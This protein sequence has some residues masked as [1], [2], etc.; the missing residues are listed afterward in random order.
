MWDLDRLAREGQQAWPRVTLSPA[1]LAAAV[2]ERLA[3]DDL[4]G[5]DLYLAIALEL[6]DRAALDLFEQRFVPGL[7]AALGR[8]CRSAAVID[9]V[10]QQVRVRVLV[11]EPDRPARIGSYTGR[12]HLG[13]WLR[14]TA[15]RTLANLARG[16]QR[17]AGAADR[18]AVGD[19]AGSMTW[20]SPERLLLDQ[21]HGG[22]LR[23]ALADGLRALPPRDR[24]L[25]RLHYLE[26]L[27]LDRIATV[28]AVNKSTVSRWLAGARDELLRRALAA[29]RAQVVAAETEELESLCTYICSRLDLSLSGL[30]APA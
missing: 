14:V 29:V 17:S 5:A 19:V 7:R 4:A 16:E 12:G 9:E 2:R 3:T 13:A 27:A 15:M 30:L 26:G 6:G 10:V 20:P 1:Q 23:A 18:A 21:R 25:L 28:Y 22:V 11:G 24:T 8:A